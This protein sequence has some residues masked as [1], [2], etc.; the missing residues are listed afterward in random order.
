MI[1]TIFQHFMKT[2]SSGYHYH[3]PPNHRIKVKSI[4]SFTIGTHGEREQT[5]SVEY[6]HDWHIWC[7]YK[8]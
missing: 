8:T 4:G 1:K 6:E 5:F 7:R 3:M 2:Y